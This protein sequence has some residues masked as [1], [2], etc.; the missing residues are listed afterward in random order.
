MRTLI[1]TFTALLAA[2]TAT[3]EPPPE[4]AATLPAASPAPASTPGAPCASPVHDDFDFWVGEWDVFAEYGCLLIEK[5]TNANGITGQSY[6]FVDPL[7]NKWRQ[8]WVSGGAVIDYSGGLTGTGSMKL[9]GTITY[10]S[11]PPSIPFTGEW[12]PNPDGT[13][14]QHFEQFDPATGQW[15]PWFTGTYIRKPA[16]SEG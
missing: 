11:G 7:T 8:I 5:W 9:E 10:Q 13:V 3:P 15:T 2:C 16:V 4:A 12:T 6:N 1:L 14:T